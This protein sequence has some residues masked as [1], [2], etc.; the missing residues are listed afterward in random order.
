MYMVTP[1]PPGEA[2]DAR[3]DPTSVRLVYIGVIIKMK[4]FP[5]LALVAVLGGLSYAFVAQ[6]APTTAPIPA[7][8]VDEE[9]SPC[10]TSNE[11]H[12]CNKDIQPPFYTCATG[13][14]NPVCAALC[15]ATFNDSVA[16]ARA[17]ACAAITA[18]CDQRVA[19]ID[20]CDNALN[21]CLG[22]PNNDPG[23]CAAQHA[24]C[25]EDSFTTFEAAVAAAEAGFNFEVAKANQAYMKC[26]R[27][28]CENN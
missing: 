13:E 4:L 14:L 22:D 25:Y 26:I 17:T 21:D 24:Q 11:N 23:I 1:L 15:R 28:C 18:A 10:D 3:Y 27:L 7:V 9:V 2:A 16:A 20:A 5:V 19:D 12:I 6:N 8:V